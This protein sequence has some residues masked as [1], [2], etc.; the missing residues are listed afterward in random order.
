MVVRTLRVDPEQV[1]VT[2]EAADAAGAVEPDVSVL[3]RHGLDAPFFLYVGAAYPYKNLARLIDAFAQLA[4]DHKLV[5]AG[6]QEQF[7]P[8][9]RG[10]RRR[11]RSR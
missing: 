5:L 1:A 10:Q 3:A 4:G 8:A 2:Y 11:G 9:L 6:D 7:G